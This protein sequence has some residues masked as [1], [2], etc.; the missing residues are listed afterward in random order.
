MSL[1]SYG[2]AYLCSSGS[3]SRGLYCVTRIVPSGFVRR[4]APSGLH[5]VDA[6]DGDSATRDASSMHSKGCEKVAWICKPPFGII[7]MAQ[8]CMA[9]QRST[10]GESNRGV[11]DRG[12]GARPQKTRISFFLLEWPILSNEFASHQI[13]NETGLGGDGKQRTCWQQHILRSMDDPA[14]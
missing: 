5:L 10:T 6:I 4:R 1:P 13:S 7:G 9:T 8:P 12:V 2:I 3:V 14:W 11:G